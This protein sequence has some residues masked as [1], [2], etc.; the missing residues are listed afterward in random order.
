[1]FFYYN[2][3]LSVP[4]KR[5]SQNDMKNNYSAKINKASTDLDNNRIAPKFNSSPFSL[6]AEDLDTLNRIS[7]KHEQALTI[8]HQL[9]E[10]IMSDAFAKQELGVE[11]Q[12][13]FA[14]IEQMMNNF[15]VPTLSELLSKNNI[16]T[17]F[18]YT[19]PFNS[20]NE[21]ERLAQL[22]QQEEESH[23]NDIFPKQKVENADK[24]MTSKE[25]EKT[26]TASFNSSYHVIN[27]QLK[28]TTP[29][30]NNLEIGSGRIKNLLTSLEETIDQINFQLKF[31]SKDPVIKFFA[32]SLA[33]PPV[34]KEDPSNVARKE[35][36]P[37]MQ[38]LFLSM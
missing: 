22:R 17:I 8:S 33:L 37:E 3:S 32:P 20:N 29:V 35:N 38:T 21:K 1:M 34:A 27:H 13:Y 36:P 10:N 19:F 2:A 26:A 28:T 5:G 16:S 24:K 14:K 25:E 18:S 11:I 12:Q 15:V 9:K 4:A 23:L 6:L 7:S 31:L 30:S